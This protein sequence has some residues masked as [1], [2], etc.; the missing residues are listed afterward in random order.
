M[1]SLEYFD[2]HFD[3]WE[4]L[5]QAVVNV[6]NNENRGKIINRA[7]QVNKYNIKKKKKWISRERLSRGKNYLKNTQKI[8]EICITK[9]LKFSQI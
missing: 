2:L 6:V 1:F 5:N 4:D 3:V 8:L 9:V 7:W